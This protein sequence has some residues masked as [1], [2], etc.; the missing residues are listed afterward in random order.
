[1]FIWIVWGHSILYFKAKTK[2]IKCSFCPIGLY[3]AR[4]Y[5]FSHFLY[6]FPAHFLLY[7][8]D[9]DKFAVRFV[10]CRKE[11]DCRDHLNFDNLNTGAC[12]HRR[13]FARM[14]VIQSERFRHSIMIRKRPCFHRITKFI[15][16]FLY[17]GPQSL[18]VILP[19]ELSQLFTVGQSVRTWLFSHKLQG[20][21]LL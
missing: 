8:S 3:G 16:L 10:I 19:M 15:H 21:G 18:C 14:T 13:N 9:E 17:R 4:C 11:L 7:V 2:N 6:W 20:S 5:R 1:V 12:I